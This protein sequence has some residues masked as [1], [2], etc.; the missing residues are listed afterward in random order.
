MKRTAADAKWSLA[1]RERDGYQCQRC[2]KFYPKKHRGLHA[3][4]IFSRAIKRT[5]TDMDNGVTLCYGCHALFHREPLE[6][7][8]FVKEWMGEDRYEALSNKARR[9]KK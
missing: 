8:E 2:E 4:H 6:F 7:H 5:R 1:I 9:I 3:A